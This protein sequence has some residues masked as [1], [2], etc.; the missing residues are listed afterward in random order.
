MSNQKN[1][2][3]GLTDPPSGS[4]RLPTFIASWLSPHQERTPLSSTP[5]ATTRPGTQHL[6]LRPVGAVLRSPPGAAGREPQAVA[7]LVQQIPPHPGPTDP[8]I[9]EH[10]SS[11]SANLSPFYGE[12]CKTTQP[13]EHVNCTPAPRSRFSFPQLPQF[14][15]WTG[16]GGGWRPASTPPTKA[17]SV[18]RSHP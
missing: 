9:S 13:Q 7:S 4:L 12:R 6:L 10:R 17:T 5:P 15:R 3:S 2:R 14:W 16:F 8:P 11:G 18:G 1:A